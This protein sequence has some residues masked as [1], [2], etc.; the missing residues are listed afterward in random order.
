[1]K[2]AR[3]FSPHLILPFWEIEIVQSNQRTLTSRIENHCVNKT[4]VVNNDIYNDETKVIS[5]VT[6]A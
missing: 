6:P 4:S 1:M 3:E 2:D 5:C